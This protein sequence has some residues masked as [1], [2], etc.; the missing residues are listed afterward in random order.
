MSWIAKGGEI[1][2]DLFVKAQISPIIPL[3]HE[4]EIST[5][6]LY[7]E[8]LEQDTSDLAYFNEGFSIFYKISAVYD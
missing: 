2:L 8:F 6:D 3:P 4:Y 1:R 7:I 5:I